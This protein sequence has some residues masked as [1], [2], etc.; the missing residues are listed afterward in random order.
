MEEGTWSIKEIT[1]GRTHPESFE[2]YDHHIDK[3]ITFENDLMKAFNNSKE[4]KVKYAK[5]EV[6]LLTWEAASDDDIREEVDADTR[7][8]VE[9][10]NEVNYTVTPCVSK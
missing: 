6:L 8:L 2:P 9:L 3:I 7:E 10:F 5:V 1:N 4:A